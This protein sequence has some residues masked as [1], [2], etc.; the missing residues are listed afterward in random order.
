M[1]NSSLLGVVMFYAVIFVCDS[2]TAP[3]RGGGNGRFARASRNDFDTQVVNCQSRRRL[4][5][6]LNFR[7]DR[8]ETPSAGANTF[9]ERISAPLA[10]GN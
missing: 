4:S 5:A 7:A 1:Y 8:H 3:I 2:F 6:L 9:A 10:G